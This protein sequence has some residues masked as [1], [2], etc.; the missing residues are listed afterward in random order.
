MHAM[1][2]SLPFRLARAAVFTAV[3]LGLGVAAHLFAGGP[4]S[5]PGAVGGTALAFAAALAAA[6]RERSAA[7]ILPLL[8][9][10]QAA[11]HLLFSLTHAVPPAEAAGQHAHSG[12]LPGLGMLVMHGWAVGL[13]AL[14]LARGEAALWALL[15]RL[16]VRL[17][18]LLAHAVPDLT[19]FFAVPATEP[20]PPRP[21][22]LRHAVRR[23]GP[24][25]QVVAAS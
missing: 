1:P 2:A 24:P 14:W 17:R 15:R 12:L 16:P 18:L 8:A 19:P 20:A 21:A 22:L 6:G 3:C 25:P 11:L 4:V 9:G 13:T 7:V 10:L 23:R 5:A